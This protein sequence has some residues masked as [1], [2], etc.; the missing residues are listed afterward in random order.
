MYVPTWAICTICVLA[1]GLLAFLGMVI[2]VII[3]QSRKKRG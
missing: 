2:A 1:G 3:Q